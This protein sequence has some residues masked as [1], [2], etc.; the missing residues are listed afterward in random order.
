MLDKL[1]FAKGFY[2]EN[3]TKSVKVRWKETQFKR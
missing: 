1:N 3:N 2:Y